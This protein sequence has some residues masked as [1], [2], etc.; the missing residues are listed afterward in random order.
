M[1]RTTTL[2]M[3]AASAFTLAVPGGTAMAQ[4]EHGTS[5]P[6]IVGGTDA[7]QTYS[8]MVSL[9]SSSGGHFCGGSLI[10]PDWVVTAAHCL[11]ADNTV[12]MQLRIGSIRTDSGGVIA[13][14]KR[15]ESH[16]EADLAV[17]Q[18]T[19]PVSLQ[20]VAIAATA[21]PGTPIRIMGWGC[22]VDPGCDQPDILQQL[23]TT[24]LPASVCG[25][26]VSWSSLCVGTP[27]RGQG[28]CLFDSGGPAVR[29]TTGSFELVGA[30][31][32][33]SHPCGKNPSIYTDVTQ[34]KSWIEQQTG[35]TGSAG[36]G[37]P[38]NSEL[39]LGR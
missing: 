14:P 32:G 35:K 13:R 19:A 18:L 38:A 39:E 36:S 20:P 12:G 16:K 37:G 9:Q 3:I 26:M 6:T 22:T 2:L 11:R 33:G 5:K 10:R 8:Y 31:H 27:D 4:T 25:D 30:T 29:G 21:A 28:A 17:I 24:I 15:F 23:D 34:Y 7:D 1:P